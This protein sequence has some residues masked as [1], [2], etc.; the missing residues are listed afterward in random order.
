M[1]S[2][3][4]EASQQSR[5]LLLAGD[6]HAALAKK[7]GFTST[8]LMEAKSYYEQVLHRTEEQSRQHLKAKFAREKLGKQILVQAEAHEAQ[9]RY[10]EALELMERAKLLLPNNKKTYLLAGKLAFGL[11]NYAVAEQ[12]FS[13]LIDSLDYDGKQLQQLLNSLLAVN[14]L[15]DSSSDAGELMETARMLEENQEQAQLLKID[16][17]IREG[18]A[19]D[20]DTWMDS[21]KMSSQ[22]KGALY[23]KIAQQYLSDDNPEKAITFYQKALTSDSTL[24]DAR[25]L[26]AVSYQH[27][28]YASLQQENEQPTKALSYLRSARKELIVLREQQPD[29]PLLT[30]T[31]NEIR[32]SI[33][34]IS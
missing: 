25:Y 28:S 31:L 6:V 11:K 24:L 12:N 13:F 16:M 34:E 27:M 1:V 15:Q 19:T 30:Y 20:A 26:L 23:S 33:Q 21:V 9:E 7:D 2:R 18:N 29:Y 22:R 8:H 4:A 3:R 14:F 17:L 10:S 5:W 32:E